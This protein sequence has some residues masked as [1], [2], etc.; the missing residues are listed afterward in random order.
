MINKP[1]VLSHFMGLIA[2]HKLKQAIEPNDEKRHDHISGK[3]LMY[4]DLQFSVSDL[5]ET[6]IQEERYARFESY[7]T[8]INWFGQSAITECMDR[9]LSLIN[10]FIR[11]Y[12]KRGLP[13]EIQITIDEHAL[14]YAILQCFADLSRSN[15]LHH[16]LSTVYGFMGY[17][18]LRTHPIIVIKAE[19]REISDLT[20]L[21]L[22][23]LNE[24]FVTCMILNGMLSDLE[25]GKISDD[26]LLHGFKDQLLYTFKYQN[27]TPESISLMITSFLT[28]AKSFQSDH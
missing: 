9:V 10:L 21:N 17:W 5:M 20:T 1:Q 8:V 26:T 11:S 12:E 3:E 28:G 23:H 4:F 22:D 25:I 24:K 15:H 27:Y 13:K 19:S 14:E 18:L 16:S 2:N 6:I 7:D